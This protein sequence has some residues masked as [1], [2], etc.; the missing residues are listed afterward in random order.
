MR[1]TLLE[2][3]RQTER[4]IKDGGLEGEKDALGGPPVKG[5]T[6]VFRT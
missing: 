1:N 6:E 2:R 3:E 5:A 4:E